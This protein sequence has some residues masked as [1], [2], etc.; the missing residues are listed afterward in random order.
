M[1]LILNN[2]LY[3]RELSKKCGIGTRN[4]SVFLGFLAFF[5]LLGSSSILLWSIWE[6]MYDLYSLKC[7]RGVLWPQ[8]W[9]MSHVSW[10]ICILLLLDELLHRCQ[11]HPADWW[12][13]WVQ[14]WPYRLSACWIWPLL[15]RGVLRHLQGNN[16]LSCFSL[17]F[18]GLLSHVLILLYCSAHTL[19]IIMSPWFRDCLTIMQCH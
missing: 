3:H 12:C 2:I 16:G 18:Y 15:R 19:R 7:V 1:I 17:Q 9:S 8:M 5:L 10:R 14:L 6:K 13:C 4:Q 11:L